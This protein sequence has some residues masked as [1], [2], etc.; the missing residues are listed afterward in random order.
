MENMSLQL[1]CA[2]LALQLALFLLLPTWL[3]ALSAPSTSSVAF[4]FEVSKLQYDTSQAF[5][6]A[7]RGDTKIVCAQRNLFGSFLYQKYSI[8]AIC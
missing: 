8:P 4:C 5:C 3:P 7:R 1:F 6:I 2:D